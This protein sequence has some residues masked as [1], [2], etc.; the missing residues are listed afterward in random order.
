LWSYLERVAQRELLNLN[1][2]EKLSLFR[3]YLGCEKPF[4]RRIP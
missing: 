2:V 3:Y 4:L 1:R